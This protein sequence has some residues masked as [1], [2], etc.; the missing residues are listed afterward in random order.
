VNELLARASLVDH[1][2]HSIVPGT[3]DRE[4]FTLMLTESDRRSA[5]DAA[6]MDSQVAFAVRRWCA[7][8]L[9]MPEHVSA[10]EYLDR[11]LAMSNE[12]A[13][14][15]LLPHSGVGRMLVD[16]GFRPGD[17]LPVG[18]LGRL[19]RART[20][21]IVRLEGVAERVARDGVS[22]AGFADAFRAAL[23]TDA[24]GAVGLKSII[25]YRCGLDFDP[26]RPPDR[27]VAERAGGWL[28]EIETTGHGRLTDPVLL[29][30]GLWEGAE[31]GLPLQIHTG[32]GDPD[33]DLHRCD[34][35][36]LTDFI[37]ATEGICPVL[38]LHTYPF[39]RQAGYLAQMFPHVFVDVGLAVTFTGAASTQVVGESLE[40]APFTKV[41]FSSDAWGLPELHVVGSWLFRRA[42]SRV[43]GAWVAAGDW[44]LADAERVVE[45]VGSGNAR[46]AYGLDEAP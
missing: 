7:P 33:L 21:T 42:M 16:T 11:R 20:E 15:R 37:R 38:L 9:D 8:L 40:L 1:H 18:E 12:T 23:R 46:R 2:T 14:A 19:A 22:A 36:L 29:R 13:A 24:A 35:L 10:E 39:Q 41:L 3:V 45:L 17:L 26:A 31:T 43:L 44:S 4:A 6:G 25:A 27:E 34:P 32:Y 28:R 30:F 5:A